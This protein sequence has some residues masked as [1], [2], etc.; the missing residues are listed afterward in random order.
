M[1]V[2]NRVLDI[3]DCPLPSTKLPTCA[4]IVKAICFEISDSKISQKDA[5]DSVTKKVI[6][7]WQRAEIPIVS[8]QRIKAKISDYFAKYYALYKA[9]SSRVAY[10]HQVQ[11]FK[12]KNDSIVFI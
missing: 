11:S 12:V 7:L 3:F 6:E 10:N 1:S 2:K 8:K 4:D 9:N 5:I